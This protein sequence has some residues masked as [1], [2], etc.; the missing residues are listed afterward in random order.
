MLTSNNQANAVLIA[1]RDNLLK[2]MA[3]EI[4]QVVQS[5]NAELSEQL[6]G[7]IQEVSV[8]LDKIVSILI[9]LQKSQESFEE[10]LLSSVKQVKWDE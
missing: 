3:N 10:H 2:P 6:N 7:S 4:K 1:I 9:N 5:S 8:K